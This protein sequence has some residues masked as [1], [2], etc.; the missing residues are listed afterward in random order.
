[1]SNR[2]LVDCHTHI[3]TKR[4]VSL[5]R[6][7][8]VN[9]HIHTNSP[10]GSEK[11]AIL[12]QEV[13]GG[14][15][16]G[17]QYWDVRNKV[18]FMNRHSIDISIVS[19]AN[20]WLDFLDAPQAVTS[21]HECNADL[22]QYCCEATE[23]FARAPGDSHVE[24]ARRIKA[25]GIMPLAE[26]VD[27]TEIV[28]SLEAIASSPS[29]CGAILG[30]RGL[31]KGLDDPALEPVWA[32]AA[33][34]GLVLFLHPHY[35]VGA[36]ASQPAGLWGTQDNGHVLPLA[37]GFPFETAAATTRLILAGVFDRHPHLRLL[38]AHSGGALPILSSRL[39]S[40]V[41]HDP[42]VCNRLH[43]DPRYYL[44]KLYYDAVAYGPEELEAVANIIGRA[45]RYKAGATA[46]MAAK[47]AYTDKGVQ[48]MVFGT[49]HPFFPPTREDGT[50]ITD[51]QTETWRSV[52]ENLEAISDVPAW[53]QSAKLG[54]FGQNAVKLFGL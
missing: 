38:V 33:E 54:V 15:T 4:L 10:D 35:G 46:P 16:V 13:S 17:P 43:H 19:L 29:L 37:L 26:G 39:A 7:R 5:L 50:V 45:D 6:A 48:R 24:A 21:A 14:R 31:G 11:L 25:F 23:L 49:D 32:K 52:T 40:C 2:I 44:G 1:M 28:K 12:P 34:L 36:D 20:P 42:H 47:G 3:Y 22:E 41:A 27:P 53:S 30:S 18:S 51:D 8:T 9:P